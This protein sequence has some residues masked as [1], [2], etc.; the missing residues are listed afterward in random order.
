VVRQQSKTV[1]GGGEKTRRWDKRGEAGGEEKFDGN[2]EGVG[3]KKSVMVLKKGWRPARKIKEEKR[4]GRT[5]VG[6]GRVWK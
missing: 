1:R 2:E 5:E 4:S 6:R 3:G